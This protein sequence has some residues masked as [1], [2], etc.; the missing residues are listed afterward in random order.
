MDGFGRV[1]NSIVN[2]DLTTARD[3]IKGPG[4][5]CQRVDFKYEKEIGTIEIESRCT[6]RALRDACTVGKVIDIDRYRAVKSYF[7]LVIGD[8]FFNTICSWNDVEYRTQ[9]DVIKAFDN[10]I[11]LTQ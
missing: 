7:W 9:D 5:W 8:Q 10:A 1:M 4:Q 11:R 3:L 2:E 6:I